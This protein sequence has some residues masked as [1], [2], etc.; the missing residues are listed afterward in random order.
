MSVGVTV[1]SD[2]TGL[3]LDMACT[4]NKCKMSEQSAAHEDN[5]FIG[6]PGSVATQPP[7]EDEFDYG[8]DCD[9][10]AAAAAV[11]PTPPE[12][13]PPIAA[14]SIPVYGSKAP[15]DVAGN[16]VK[17]FTR[18]LL[19]ASQIS[20]YHD[21]S[22]NCLRLLSQWFNENQN[23]KKAEASVAYK[24]QSCKVTDSFLQASD[25]AR[26]KFS[27]RTRLLAAEAA[28]HANRVSL[29]RGAFHLRQKKLNND[30]KKIKL[31]EAVA[32]S[33]VRMA[34]IFLHE[35]HGSLYN[36]HNLVADM[37]L[38]GHEVVTKHLGSLQ[39]FVT[40]YK[41]IHKCGR[42]PDD[43]KVLFARR[44]PASAELGTS[45]SLESA[46]GSSATTE[47]DAIAAA[48]Q[49]P[50]SAS[51]QHNEPSSTSRALNFT[52]GSAA[53]G[54]GSTATPSNT[55][56][57]ESLAILLAS[58]QRDSETAKSL[59]AADPKLSDLFTLGQ[60]LIAKEGGLTTT[61]ASRIT[62]TL[63]TDIVETPV[64]KKPS[65]KPPLASPQLIY[66][67]YKGEYRFT[68]EDTPEEIAAWEHCLT[69]ALQK[70]KCRNDCII[71][72][73]RPK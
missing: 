26:E 40:V 32:E 5:A 56:A 39:E 50:P 27:E 67:K 28:D 38:V 22:R 4:V 2:K 54:K 34:N 31:T 20:A 1:S 43:W 37:L 23:I 18:T 35:I 3:S 12:N 57:R 61:V 65:N 36:P 24:P 41:Q 60:S 63:E 62:T 69:E 6:S 55:A 45:G 71:N 44:F 9:D 73:I 70:E 59:I 7:L 72:S 47:G 13:D 8:P 64:K 30:A 66:N 48:H 11:A 53:A 33:L 51:N 46:N 10:A 16:Y 68:R 42:V 21:I 29:E 52:P 14:D 25:E 15:S 49:V 19:W 17:H 58:V